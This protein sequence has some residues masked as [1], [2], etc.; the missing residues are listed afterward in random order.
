MMTQHTT[1]ATP[2]NTQQAYVNNN[3]AGYGNQGYNNGTQYAPP[4]GAPPQQQYGGSNDG[5]YGQQAGV[6]Q[7]Q[8]TYQGG[9]K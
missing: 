5:Y 3:P 9:Y 7:P 4:P 8:N 6:A 2:M 1:N